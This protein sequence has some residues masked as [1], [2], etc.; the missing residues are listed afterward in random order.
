MLVFLVIVSLRHYNA[1]FN[2]SETPEQVIA[3]TTR[4]KSSSLQIHLWIEVSMMD[5]LG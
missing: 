4:S 5:N 3:I 2:V 1:S